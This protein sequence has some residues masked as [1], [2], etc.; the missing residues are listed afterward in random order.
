MHLIDTGENHEIDLVLDMFF[1]QTICDIEMKDRQGTRSNVEGPYFLEGA[2]LVIDE[3]KVCG[4]TEPLLIRGVV[5]D[6]KGNPIP[7]VEVDLWWAT[8]EGK[9]SGYT[10]DLPMEYFRGKVNTDAEG[11]YCVMGSMPMEY[12]MTTE[13]HGPTGGLIEMLGSQ[14]M[15]TKHIHQKYRKAGYQTL[16]TQAYFSGAAYIDEDPVK[17]VFEDL[18]YDLKEE[19]GRPVLDL[20]IVIDV[21][22]A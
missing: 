20:E 15:R 2:P 3:V 7:D 19:D 21:V 22:K 17:A 13:R 6:I 1:N 9:Y 16:T 4:D 12:P 18:T 8:P 10:D 14:G 11:K 5:K